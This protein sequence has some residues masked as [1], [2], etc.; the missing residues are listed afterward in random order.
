[1]G[2]VGGTWETSELPLFA[3]WIWTLLVA[4]DVS[5]DST[6]VGLSSGLRRERGYEIEKINRRGGVLSS[7]LF[8]FFIA[9]AS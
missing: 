8:F 1:M 5:Q 4:V 2:I 9:T 6:N 3:C 7:F